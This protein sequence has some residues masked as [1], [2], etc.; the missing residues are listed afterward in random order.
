[1]LIKQKLLIGTGF[2]TAIYLYLLVA[3]YILDSNNCREDWF[4]CRSLFHITDDILRLFA[5]LFLLVLI[6]YRFRDDVFSSVT[7]LAYWF[8]P[9]SVIFLLAYPFVLNNDRDFAS[10]VLA[11]LFLVVGLGL[12]MYK[13]GF[14]KQIVR[15]FQR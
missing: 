2:I 11:C 3:Y 14:F 6:S 5:V 4:Y 13:S 8:I 7:R 12:V 1:M 9:L 10:Q 15:R